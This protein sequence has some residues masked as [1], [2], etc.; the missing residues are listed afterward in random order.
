MSDQSWQYRA[1]PGALQWMF[2]PFRGAVKFLILACGAG[3]LLQILLQA[4]GFGGFGSVEGWSSRTGGFLHLFG[5]VPR[6]TLMG[7]R[8]WQPFTYLF[9]HGGFGHL[10]FNMLPLWM[11][12]SALEMEWGMRRFL[13]YYFVTGVGAG[14]TVILFSP[15]SL[16]PTIGASGAILGLL[17]AFGVLHPNQP[18]FVYGIFPVKAKWMVIATGVLT[19]WA[20]WAATGSGVSHIAH[21]GG[22]VLG[23]AY[24]KR[25]WRVGDLYREIRWRV[26]RRR[27]HVIRKDRGN[28]DPRYPYH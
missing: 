13:I 17:L 24:L 11:F 28:G 5:L 19:L 27:F 26:R 7:F 25:I 4:A 22:M 3:F 8:F 12:G 20:S 23:F 18:I 16:T 14:L 21:L 6:E 10:L 2:P 15:L 9:L 1:R